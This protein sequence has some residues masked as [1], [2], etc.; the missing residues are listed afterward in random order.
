MKKIQDALNKSAKSGNSEELALQL[1]NA[2]P[3][4]VIAFDATLAIHFVNQAAL[5]FFVLSKKQLLEKNLQDLLGMN[6]ALLEHLETVVRKR[7]GVTLHDIALHG[8]SVHSVTILALESGDIYLM[9]IKQQPFQLVDEWN[10]KT[11]YS[12]KSSQMI[13]QMLAHEVKNPLAGIH[14]AAQLLAGSNLNEDDAE[15]A[16]LIAREAV[17]I[18][19]LVDKFNVF[20]DVPPGHY[21]AINMHEVLTHVAKMATMTYGDD[22]EIIESFD[23]SLPE[24]RGHFDHLV[25]AK[26]NLIKNAA[27]AFKNK[28]GKISI[29]TFYD[30]AAAVHPDRL[31]KLPLCI[32]IEDNG[33]GMDS[34]T[35]RRIF[36]PY[37]TTKLQGQGLGLPIV[38]KIVNDHG[39]VIGVTSK[40]GKTVFRLSFPVPK[41]MIKK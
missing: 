29:R 2:L 6:N 20:H 28:K 10:E 13:A 24:I 38:S 35:I 11:K 39:G 27:E 9:T 8:R 19:G 4:V 18:Q 1:L 22:V 36:E 41:D 30:T 15:L 32:E 37:F 21:K 7:Q 26:L 31:E 12:L 25:Q 16:Q 5:E 34:E 14:G 3:D 40:P 17:R 33:Q 23:P